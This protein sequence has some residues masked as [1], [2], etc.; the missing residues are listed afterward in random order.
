MN[1][2][3]DFDLKGLVLSWNSSFLYFYMFGSVVN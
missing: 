2:R 3:L 1:F